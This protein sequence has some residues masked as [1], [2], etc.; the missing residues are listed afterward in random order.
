MRI[1]LNFI[2]TYTILYIPTCLHSVKLFEEVSVDTTLFLETLSLN[3]VY[4]NFH[5]RNTALGQL[6]ASC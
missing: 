5:Q 6:F 4:N 2:L 1:N 3:F